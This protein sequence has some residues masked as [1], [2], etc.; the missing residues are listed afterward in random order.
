MVLRL[1]WD[2]GD[3]LL[4]LLLVVR[5]PLEIFLLIVDSVSWSLEAAANW[6]LSVGRNPVMA[7]F[8][9]RRHCDALFTR[10]LLLS[11]ET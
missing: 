11:I 8:P 1:G 7:F 9:R 10:E 2:W 3:P 4:V 6:V 5:L